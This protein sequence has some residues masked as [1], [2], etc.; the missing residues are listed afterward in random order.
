MWPIG[1]S[2]DLFDVRWQ[3]SV[4]DNPTKKLESA[5]KEKAFPKTQENTILSQDYVHH[6]QVFHVVLSGLREDTHVI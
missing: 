3:L 5:R 2:F 6:V 1:Q 4:C